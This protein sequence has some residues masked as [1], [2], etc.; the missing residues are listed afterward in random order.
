LANSQTFS[1]FKDHQG[2][3]IKQLPPGLGKG[4][5]KLKLRRPI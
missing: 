5:Q 4:R 1:F 2:A 3:I